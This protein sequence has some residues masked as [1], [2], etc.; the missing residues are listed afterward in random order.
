MRPKTTGWI[1]GVMSYNGGIAM[2]STVMGSDDYSYEEKDSLETILNFYDA[3]G[4]NTEGMVLSEPYFTENYYF[5]A[6][7]I[8]RRLRIIETPVGRFF[9][10][11]GTVFNLENG[12]ENRYEMYSS[13]SE[14]ALSA[15]IYVDQNSGYRNYFAVLFK[16]DKVVGYVKLGEISFRTM[17]TPDYTKYEFEGSDRITIRD[18]FYSYV[19]SV[20]FT[21][22]T[23][24]YEFDLTDRNLC[25]ELETSAD[26]KY[27]LWTAS[28]TSG[29]DMWICNIVVK[30]NETGEIKYIGEG[31]GMYG[32]A[33]E[34][35]FFKNGDLYFTDYY[36]LKVFDPETAKVKFD[37]SENFPFGDFKDQGFGRYLF[38]FRRNP[39]DMSFIL[40]YGEMPEGY[41]TWDMEHFKNGEHE[42]TYKFGFTDAEGNLL[43]SYDTGVGVWCD[44]FGIQGVSMRYAEDELTLIVKGSKGNDG[45]SGVFDMGTKKFTVDEETWENETWNNS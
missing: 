11:G 36:C 24:S 2:L 27:T 17:N 26:G 37:I 4:K 6:P 7:Y 3:D 41:D 43:E 15:G 40:V 18:S 39:E 1:N 5:S 38:T 31:G 35:G 19:L 10:Y 13:F 14:G 8:S 34:A 20:D 32:G 28:E 16:N 30:N 25:T 33:T 21:K 22:K 12:E 9:S 44:N 42:F 29:G 45:F 23:F